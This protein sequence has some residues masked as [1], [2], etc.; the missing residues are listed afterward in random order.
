[1]ERKQPRQIL[2]KF[3]N[4]NSYS[5]HI[6]DLKSNF[7]IVDNRIFIFVNEKNLKEMFLT[8]NINK[9]EQYS[10][11]NISTISIHRKQ[12]TNTLYTLNAMNKLIA[13]ENEGVFDPTFQ[14]SWELYKNSFIL[15]NEIGVKIIPI[16]LFNLIKF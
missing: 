7:N 11:N 9:S 4:N 13:D 3:S 12:Q 1:M 15:N 14:L 16:R 8:F 5:S 6:N 2:C 10:S